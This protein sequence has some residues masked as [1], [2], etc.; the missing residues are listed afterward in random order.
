[1]RQV[2]R[3]NSPT[4]V[5]PIA[6]LVLAGAILFIVTAAWILWGEPPL[7]SATPLPGFA[8]QLLVA[9]FIGRSWTAWRKG[10]RQEGELGRRV[11][12]RHA[13]FGVWPKCPS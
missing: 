4:D 5:T 2:S 8:Y 10:R 11:V 9:T 6:S 3:E 7:P 12:A 1:V 13:S